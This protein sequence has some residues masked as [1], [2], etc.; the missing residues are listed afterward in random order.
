MLQ[1][2]ADGR[3]S[4]Y[5]VPSPRKAAATL[6]QKNIDSNA[7][8]HFISNHKILL[9]AVYGLIR[10]TSVQSV[11]V[12]ICRPRWIA[13]KRAPTKWMS[14]QYT[15]LFSIVFQGKLN[16]LVAQP[17]QKVVVLPFSFQVLF[18]TVPREQQSFNYFLAILYVEFRRFTMVQRSFHLATVAH[19][20][21]LQDI[22]QFVE[23]AKVRYGVNI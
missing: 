17:G 18:E 3:P 5:A 12:Q 21:G 2:P 10:G 13:P 19:C 9:P 8:V 22:G 15:T 23:A 16:C 1:F 6:T 4:V 7:L 11:V 20:N 14:Q